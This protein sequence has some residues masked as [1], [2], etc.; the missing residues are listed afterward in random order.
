MRCASV[1]AFAVELC[2]TNITSYLRCSLR[3]AH[4][5]ENREQAKKTY[6]RGPNVAATTAVWFTLDRWRAETQEEALRAKCNSG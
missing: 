1:A 6:C 4:D 5:R 2:N 3:S